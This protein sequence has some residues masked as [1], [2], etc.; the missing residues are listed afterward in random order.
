MPNP[1]VYFEIAGRDQGVLEDFY[2]A[3]FDWQL[4]PANEQYTHVAPGGGING[5]IGKAMDGGP[6]YVTFYA[7]VASIAE[8]LTVVEGRGGQ[9]VMGPEQMPNGPLIALFTDPEGRTV[10]LIQAGTMRNG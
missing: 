4:T 3:V 2:R 8:T 6:G 7:E 9:R 10:G 5:G 1:I